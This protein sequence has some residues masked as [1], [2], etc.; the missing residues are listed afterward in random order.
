MYTRLSDWK[1]SLCEYDSESCVVSWLLPCHV[2][3][4][5]NMSSYGLHFISY[6]FFVLCIRNIYGWF[7]YVHDHACPSHHAAQCLGLDNKEC[8]EYYMVVDGVPSQCTYHSDVDA[9]IYNIYGCVHAN[10]IYHALSFFL[11]F[12]YICLFS[13]NYSA[14]VLTIQHRKLSHSNNLVASTCLSTCGLAQEYREIV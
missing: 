6:A 12:S 9:C 7:Y 10:P 5:L 2:Y 8:S 11:C 13:M 14:R 3:A 4:K 1:S